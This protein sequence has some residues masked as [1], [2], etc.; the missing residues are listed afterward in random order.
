MPRPAKGARAARRAPDAGQRR[1][2][3]PVGRHRRGGG[4]PASTGDRV[5]RGLAF[6]VRIL[7]TLRSTMHERRREFAVLRCLGASRSVVTGAILWQSLLIA[8]CGSIGSWMVYMALSLGLS[9]LIKLQVG[10]SMGFPLFDW[11]T[12]Q[13]CVAILGLGLLSAWLPA[14]TLYRSNLQD[15]LNTNG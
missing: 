14:R 1:G 15:S 13:T 8:L 12:L 9:S 5:H 4:L 11:I 10:V 2:G 3:G 7:A 6:R